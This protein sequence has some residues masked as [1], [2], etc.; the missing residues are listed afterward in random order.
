MLANIEKTRRCF[1][2]LHQARIQQLKVRRELIY[3]AEVEKATQPKAC[4]ENLTAYASASELALATPMPRT[5]E[6]MPHL[7]YHG[8]IALLMG[9]AEQI[10]LDKQ[11]LTEA[12]DQ[13][14]AERD[15]LA[16][17]WPLP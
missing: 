9:R 15:A 13:C 11:E 7:P 17:P 14:Q 12:R 2:E 8:T 16:T 5:P 1:N 4:E 6:G 10:S 3:Q